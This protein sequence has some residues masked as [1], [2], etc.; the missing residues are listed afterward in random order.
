MVIEELHFIVDPVERDQFL[1]VEGRVWTGFLRTC[2][3]FVKKEVWVPIDDPGRVVVM[4]W[5]ASMEQW[6]RI[7]PEQVAEVDARMGEWLREVD[8]F[9]E[10]DVVRQDH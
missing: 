5:W 6:K 8:V 2:D 9:R 10:H 3:G 1:E 7:T 4:I